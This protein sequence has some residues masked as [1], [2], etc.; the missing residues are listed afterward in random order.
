[1]SAT[2]VNDEHPALYRETMDATKIDPARVREEFIR[3]RKEADVH[4]VE[5]W[6]R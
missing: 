4:L 6:K 3:L 2:R 5:A 1:M